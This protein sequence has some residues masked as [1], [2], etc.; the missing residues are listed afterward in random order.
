MLLLVGVWVF[1]GAGGFL[2]LVCA[3]CLGLV[4]CVLAIAL[5]LGLW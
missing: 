3:C 2:V 4:E 1:L 5:E